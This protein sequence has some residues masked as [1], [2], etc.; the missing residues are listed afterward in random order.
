MAADVSSQTLENLAS[1]PSREET[2]DMNNSLRT[3]SQNKSEDARTRGTTAGL[4]VPIPGILFGLGALCL[5]V[6]PVNPAL[7]QGISPSNPALLDTDGTPGPSAGD[8][9]VYLQWFDEGSEIAEVV[10]CYSACSAHSGNYVQLESSGAVG[11]E[12]DTFYMVDSGGVKTDLKELTL[13]DDD[14]EEFWGVGWENTQPNHMTT[15]NVEAC[16]PDVICGVAAAGSPVRAVKVD[17]VSYQIIGLDE[18]PGDG[19]VDYIRV[20]YFG[21]NATCGSCGGG[22]SHPNLWL[23]VDDAGGGEVALFFV[24]PNGDGSDTTLDVWPPFDPN[25]VVPVELQSFTIADAAST[26]PL[27]RSAQSLLS[28]MALP[29]AITL[30]RR[31]KD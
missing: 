9:Q 21:N 22:S 24:I 6:V 3:C 8:S 19:I 7:A 1:S 13:T 25:P 16:N 14:G 18:D 12:Y 26:W 2:V 23:P 29:L 20:P 17:S 11:S 15:I 27:S 31:R 30:A 28:L 4:L 5:L 10:S